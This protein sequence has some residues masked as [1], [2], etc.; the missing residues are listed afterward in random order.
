MAEG[1]LQGVTVGLVFTGSHCTMEAVIPQVEKLKA[2]GAE[3]YAIFSETV[4]ATDNRFYEAEAFRHIIE[5]LVDHPVIHTIPGAEPIGPKKLLDVAVVIPAT[6]NTVAKLANGITDTAAA[7]A[8]KAHLRNQRP[9]VIAL[10]TNDAL[11]M[12]AKNIGLL[13]NTR[14]IYFV[15]FRQ[16]DPAEKA[17]SM[18]ADL[19]LTLATVRAALAGRQLQPVILGPVL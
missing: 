6:G 17:T 15:P 9:V 13:L 14:N 4:Y 11:G 12:N 19:N 5:K 7:M 2:E 8:V 1:I 18:T 3:L 10:S 16:D